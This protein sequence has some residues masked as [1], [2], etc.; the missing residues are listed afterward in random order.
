MKSARHITLSAA[1]CLLTAICGIACGKVDATQHTRQG[2][3]YFDQKKYAEA[4][5]EFRG[6]LQQDPKLGAVR[7]KLGDAYMEIK[8]GKN[9]LREYVRAAD[10]LPNDAGAQV[11][12]GELL[13]MAGAFEDVKS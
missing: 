7:L 1:A 11:K 2:N 3:E 9:A 13:L 6:A 8:D 12:A 5:V 10:L 4:I